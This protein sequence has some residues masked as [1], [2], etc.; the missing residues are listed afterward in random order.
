MA[1]QTFGA[2]LRMLRKQANMTQQTVAEALHIDRSTYTKYETR[3]VTPDPQGLL[4]LAQL[5]GVTA[6]Y[7]L[8]REEESAPRV[9]SDRQA[10]SLLLSVEETTLLQLFRQLP[11]QERDTL[12][13]QAKT[14]NKERQP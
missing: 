7:L 1:A 3:G 4:R 2:R 14:A 10:E 11:P 5:F 6:D 8:G 9:L 12:L 13:Q